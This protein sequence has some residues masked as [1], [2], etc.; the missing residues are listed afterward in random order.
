MIPLISVISRGLQM[1]HQ[2]AEY[3]NWAPSTEPNGGTAMNCIWKTYQKEHPGWHD[4]DCSWYIYGH[5]YGEQH[6]LCQ[7]KKVK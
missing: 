2:E 4:A 7:I 5:E 6:A 1:S 3:T